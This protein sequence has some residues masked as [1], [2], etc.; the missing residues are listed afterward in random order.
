MYQKVENWFDLVALEHHI[1]DLWRRE[2]TFDKLL[3][4]NRDKP[5]WSFLD[6]PI[7]ANNPM[8]VH[9]AWGRTLK[10]A[11][12][13]YWAMNGR[14]LRYQNGFD[15]QGLWVEVEVEKELGFSTKRDIEDYGIDKFVNL[16]KER[17][18]KYSDVQTEQSK[19]LGYWMDWDHSYYTMSEENNYTIWTFLKKCHERGLI[20]RGKD[21]MPWCPRCG[22]GISQHEMQEG[23]KE[24][25]H[26]SVTVRFPLVDREKE[27]LLVWTT[28]PWTLSSNVAAA[29][30]PEL[31]YVKARQGEWTYYIIKEK[32]EAVLGPNGKWERLEEM[33][34]R[35]LLEMDLRYTGP[36]DELPA[37]AEAAAHHRLIPW[38]EISA[39]E[40]TGIVHIAP[41][42]GAEDHALGGQFGL[43][44]VA[45]IDEAGVFAEGFGWLT[46]RM[47]G[48]V[49]ED[50]AKDLKQRGI[51]YAREKYAHTYPHC[52]RCSEELLFRL[53]DE[54]FI[55]MDP[56]RED[57]K[58]SARE[59]KWIPPFGR[60]LELTWL[61]NMHDWMISKKRF[62]GL[63][64]PIWVCE[65]CGAFDVIGGRE[66]LKQRAVEGWE[67][68]E[69]NTPHRPWIDAVKIKCP[70]CGGRA[71]R[72]PDVG[73]PWLDAGIVPYSTVHYNTDPD[74]WS[75]WIPADLVLECF[76]G[77]FRNWFYALLAMSTMMENMAPFKTL[78]G[79]ALVRD[80]H[81]EEMHKSKG[82]AIWFEDAAEKM[83]VEVMR[84]LYC[85]HD[86]ANNLNF[87]YGPAKMV[88]GK[89]MNTLWNC[90]SFYANY[91]RIID[92]RPPAE[93]T[94]LAQ[95]PDFDRW[96]I[97]R[98]QNL[99]ADC[100]ECFEGYNL[101]RACIQVEQ[102]V[103]DLSNWYIRHNRRRFWRSEDEADTRLAYETLYE[104]LT[105][106]LGLLAPMMP[107]LTEAM[108][109]NI[110]RGV[111]E[112]APESVH[113]TDYPVA[114][115]E[116]V[117]RELVED[118]DALIRLTT[119]ALSAREKAKIKVRQ[120]L[121]RLV[122]APRNAAEARATERFRDMLAEDLNVK[123]VEVLQ[124]GAACPARLEVKP[125]M[126][127]L[128]PK[129]GKGAGP[130]FAAIRE[131][132]E[133][134]GERIQAGERT[135]SF[136][137]GGEPVAVTLDEL[138]V[139]ELDPE[140]QSV[141]RHENG[142]VAVDTEV[143]EELAREGLMRD[144]LRQM[145]VARKDAGL[146]VE[147]RIRVRYRT[148]SGEL[149][150]AIEA[151]RDFVAAE[152][153]CLDLQEDASL[154]DGREVKVAG[155]KATVE[156][157]KAA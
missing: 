20:Y 146:E 135:F 92:Y 126:K 6:G 91:A 80:E 7:T 150:E 118:M 107:M 96:L 69:G 53:V 44:S 113:L 119:V 131:Q 35:A 68:F 117:D 10:D 156:I 62:W 99:V 43:P 151:F 89:F 32:A 64:L 2:A 108:Y 138:L 106:L 103:E 5:P 26:L 23:Y 139:E 143:T 155:R 77:Q 65:D 12:Q 9:H 147:D 153:L 124:A 130:V 81:G 63:A 140:G 14:R 127:K 125:D 115:P 88:R 79:H 93:P 31:T 27:A 109:Q 42:C 76:P 132:A 100:R 144:F 101:R 61:D 28:T 102:F 137:A 75:R 66:E 90:Y 82:N 57:I 148:E 71:G 52:W 74:Y 110:V 11:F 73:N 3:E 22:T 141:V 58:R 54:W 128:G 152:L 40:G 149:R 67:A 25:K 104:T 95:R 37:A 1:L 16:C 21:V 78:V 86:I 8:G 94:P 50:V 136:D 56:W 120:P 39:A 49:A 123:R 48:E 97:S 111:V 157:E 34:G 72:I 70:K 51:L 85:N 121:G 47:A 33:P 30:H 45:P 59:V 84:W 13:R 98:L 142:W 83:G 112:G 18:R 55:A 114:R 122:V 17:V 4:K 145:Q 154:A 15:C 41:G 38:E 24:K 134:L 36:F 133:R 87:G 29:V 116:I 60:E 46:G 129:L 105:T 19:R